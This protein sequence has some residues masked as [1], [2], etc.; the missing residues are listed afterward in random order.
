MWHY[1]KRSIRKAKRLF[2]SIAILDDPE[3]SGMCLI[4]FLPI[5]PVIPEPLHFIIGLKHVFQQLI[6]TDRSTEME[7]PQLPSVNFLSTTSLLLNSEVSQLFEYYQFAPEGAGIPLWREKKNWISLTSVKSEW[8]S[9][10]FYT[11]SLKYTKSSQYH[12][13]PVSNLWLQVVGKQTPTFDN[14]TS[15]V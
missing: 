5:K 13:V 14:T 9:D 2:L 6:Y 1:K 4:S 11:C 7:I 10:R 8:P 15:S 3:P 12:L